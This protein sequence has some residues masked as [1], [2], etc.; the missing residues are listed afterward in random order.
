PDRITDVRD[1][2]VIRGL[3][4]RARI[5]RWRC[6]ISQAGTGITA[7]EAARIAELRNCGTGKQFGTSAIPQFSMT[8]S[9]NSA[10]H[11]PEPEL[12]PP[13]TPWPRGPASPLS[14]ESLDRLARWLDDGVAVPGTSI[15]FGLDPIIGL[16][17]GIGD[18][19]GALAS[20][21]FVFAGWRRGLPAI[22]LVRMVAN[23]LIDSLG[24]TLPI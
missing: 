5:I 15:R 16:I 3:H 19:I 6:A 22:T 8:D 1:Q 13:G 11:P 18:A 21:I 14:D 17:P 9:H 12:I 24:G 23:I 7:G 4:C 2:R 20:F 10:P